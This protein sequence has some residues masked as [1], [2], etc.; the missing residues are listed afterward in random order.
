MNSVMLAVQRDMKSFILFALILVTFG[1]VASKSAAQ[2]QAGWSYIEPAGRCYKV[3]FWAADILGPSKIDKAINQ[4]S[5][6][7]RA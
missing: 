2:C 6:W 3:G 1:A 4:V 7:S 5:N